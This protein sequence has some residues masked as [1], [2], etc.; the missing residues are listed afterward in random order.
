M[1]FNPHD[2]QRYAIEY[3]LSHPVTAAI[4][5]MGL[6]KSVITLT[7]IDLL[8]NDLFEIRKVLVVAPLR[9][10]STTWPD[11]IRKWDHLSDLRFSVAVGTEKNASPR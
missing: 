10:A 4:L 7:A 11:E 8:L 1:K 9:V 3:I 5:D 2:Y 6:G